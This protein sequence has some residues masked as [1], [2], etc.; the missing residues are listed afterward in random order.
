M[1]KISKHIVVLNSTV[2][3]RIYPTTAVYPFFLSSH[4]IFTTT[5]QILGHKVY[6]NKKYRGWGQGGEINQALYAHMNNKRK[7]SKKNI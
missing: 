4:R 1:H 3:N 7:K 2:K 6:L 5:D